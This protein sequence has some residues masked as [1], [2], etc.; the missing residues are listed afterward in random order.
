MGLFFPQTEIRPGV[1][2]TGFARYRQ[3]M[4]RDWKDFI[5]VGFM[6]LLYHIPFG[7]GLGYAILSKSL[8]VMLVSSLAGGFFVGP[9][10]ACMYD[11][12]LRRLRDD[13][14]DW[15]ICYKK[16]MRQNFRASLLPGVIQCI[17]VG[18]IAFSLGLLWWSE[19]A[20]SLGSIALIILSSLFM[21]MILTI[22]WPQVVLFDQRPLIQIKNCILFIITHLKPALGAAAIQV[23]WWTAVFLFL[24][25][26]AFLVPVLGVWY[27][28][29]LAMFTI[30]RSLNDAF[31]IEEQI[32]EHF[33]G[34]IDKGED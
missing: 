2:Y 29:F 8:L 5:L 34:Q 19:G 30:Y 27:I 24:P 17:F 6:T 15:W 26:S 12:I 14:S 23:I 18:C 25:W 21:E 9:G 1:R 16:S 31:R 33:P 11:I 13:R 22:W 28:L 10:L 7:L 32:E 4:E 3:V 20:V